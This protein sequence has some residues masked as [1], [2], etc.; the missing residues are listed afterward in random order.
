MEALSWLRIRLLLQLHGIGPGALGTDQGDVNEALVRLLARQLANGNVA[1]FEVPLVALRVL[2][3]LP[4]SADAA[5]AV[6]AI[7]LEIAVAQT[8]L[9]L[10]ILNHVQ[11]CRGS[12]SSVH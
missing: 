6:S 1:S 7:P 9:L 12:E 10:G 5:G 2:K 8:V 3:C 11:N 4:Q